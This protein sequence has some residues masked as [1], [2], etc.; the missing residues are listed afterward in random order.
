[1][2][3]EQLDSGT[4]HRLRKAG[5]CFEANG[6][7]SSPSRVSGIDGGA[8]F[9]CL[10]PQRRKR[11]NTSDLCLRE[12]HLEIR[13][14]YRLDVRRSF[15]ATPSRRYV[16]GPGLRPGPSSTFVRIV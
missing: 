6:G 13:E 4:T 2:Q 3:L 12:G 9:P 8:G 14:L 11:A 1:M 7:E 10:Q 15:L 16:E 5:W